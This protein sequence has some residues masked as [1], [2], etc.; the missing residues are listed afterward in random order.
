MRQVV[1]V[2]LAPLVMACACSQ[3]PPSS[4]GRLDQVEEPT[5]WP[6]ETGDTID[7]DTW[8][9]LSM[10]FESVGKW[11]FESTEKLLELHGPEIRASDHGLAAFDYTLAKVEYDGKRWPP[12]LACPPAGLVVEPGDD[13]ETTDGALI[14]EPESWPPGLPCDENAS[15]VPVMVYRGH[16]K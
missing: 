10:R 12:K 1:T 9:E 15:Y 7:L 11:G 6:L 16:V 2:A 4:A 3:E 8:D 5:G 13:F 14:V